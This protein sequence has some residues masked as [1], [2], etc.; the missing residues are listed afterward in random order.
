[1]IQNNSNTP[2]IIV[3]LVIAGVALL[4]FFVLSGSALP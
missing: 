1:M 2:S 4:T 3:F